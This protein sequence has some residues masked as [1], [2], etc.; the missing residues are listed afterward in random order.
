MAPKRQKRGNSF[1]DIDCEDKSRLDL[2]IDELLKLQKSMEVKI[3]KY[4][5]D[6][7]NVI[8]ELKTEINAL[9]EDNVKLKNTLSSYNYRFNTIEQKSLKSFVEIAGIPK[10][11]EENL[12]EVVVLLGEKVG[13]GINSDNISSVYRKSEAN[14]S[15]G[16][17]GPVIVEIPNEHIHKEF[18][19]KC[20]IKKDLKTS[21]INIDDRPLYVNHQLTKTS[22]YMLSK[23]KEKQKQGML[24]F[25]WVSDGSVLVRKNENSPTIKIYNINQLQ[26]VTNK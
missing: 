20:R 5:D 19:K 12:V 9:K 22:K 1:S 18:V 14:L 4:F 26:S 23:A 7:C 21:I 8:K 2:K 17:P 10:K 13:C 25:V 11:K 24:K 6:F 16:V 15:E 3:D